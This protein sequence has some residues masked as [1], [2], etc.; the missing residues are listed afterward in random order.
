MS[1][2]GAL[3]IYTG[4]VE[5]L[6]RTRL[7]YAI[8]GYIAHIQLYNLFDGKYYNRRWNLGMSTT[9]NQNLIEN[10]NTLDAVNLNMYEKGVL[11]KGASINSADTS[12][13]VNVHVRK[14]TDA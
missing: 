5:H 13:E 10:R 3:S 2:N 4:L 12:W 9:L 14:Q 8:S 6:R 1:L 11:G 7:Q